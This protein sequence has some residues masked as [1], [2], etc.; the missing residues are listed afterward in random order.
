VNKN[1]I[2]MR[3]V[4]PDKR[5]KVPSGQWLISGNPKWPKLSAWIFRQLNKYGFIKN[6]WMTMV[7]TCHVVQID[8]QT[9]IPAALRRAQLNFEAMYA[10]LR[11]KELL[12]GPKQFAEFAANTPPWDIL[13]LGPEGF[14]FESEVRLSKT[15]TEIPGYH[16]DNF[17][18]RH[19]AF[20]IPVRVI[21]H[22]DGYL[23]I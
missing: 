13:Q 5:E 1:I 12:I 22:L 3:F 6:P 10:G 18:V 2:H 16:R 23:W 21:P 20:N 11:P 8:T 4:V 19:V 14:S 15:S 17:P 9:V 7:D